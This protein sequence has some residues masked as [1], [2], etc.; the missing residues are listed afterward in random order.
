[1]T[2]YKRLLAGIAFGLVVG[3]A[4]LAIAQG[5][6]GAPPEGYYGPETGSIP[7]SECP[8]QAAVL[9]DAGRKVDVFADDQCPSLDETKRQAADLSEL[10]ERSR[11]TDALIE[12]A[13]HTVE[14]TTGEEGE[15]I[16]DMRP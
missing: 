7:A 4:G 9:E 12:Q 15:L 13:V 1:M 10:Y 5:D 16:Y 11:E 14:P 3:F 6:A 8:E 2:W